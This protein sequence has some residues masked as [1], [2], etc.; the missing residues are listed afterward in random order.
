MKSSSGK[1]LSSIINTVN[2]LA[3]GIN[4]NIDESTHGI[5]KYGEKV[6]AIKNDYDERRD[7]VNLG[8]VF[9]VSCYSNGR[10]CFKEKPTCYIP[11]LGEEATAW[12][13][14]E[15]Y[16]IVDDNVKNILS[17]IDS[18]KPD[19]IRCAEIMKQAIGGYSPKKKVNIFSGYKD[20]CTLVAEYEPVI[21]GFAPL[22]K[23]E[24]E[25]KQKDK[26]KQLLYS[27]NPAYNNDNDE[28]LNLKEIL[29]TIYANMFYKINVVF[30]GIFPGVD[31]YKNSIPK[32]I[33][34]P[35]RK[36]KCLANLHPLILSEFSSCSLPY[37]I[38][39]IEKKYK[40]YIFK[41]V[42]RE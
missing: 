42:W 38:N 8:S 18:I 16:R 19:I 17:F 24:T 31:K 39:E 41:T 11:Y 6:I 22:I 35:Y 15:Y 27:I 37:L 3:N 32:Y 5:A 30:S 29:A 13:P 34:L 23:N 40:E 25:N 2:C 28:V 10:Y 21:M 26:L 9:T 12:H 36:T 33:L 4:N 1:I 7:D 20:F 14:A